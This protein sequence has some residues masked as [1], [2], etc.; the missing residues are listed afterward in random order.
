MADMCAGAC[1]DG[2]EGKREDRIGGV[3]WKRHDESLP[4]IRPLV[5]PRDRH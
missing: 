5:P 3:S 4:A 2:R 1:C